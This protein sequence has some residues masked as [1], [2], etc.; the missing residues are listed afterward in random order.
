LFVGTLE[1]RK[2]LP[3][4]LEAIG[5]L[6]DRGWEGELVLVGGRGMDETKI[7]E[8]VERRRIGRRVLKLG[9]V[10]PKHLPTIYR[11]A[12]ALVNPSL[13]EGFGL[14]PLEAMACEVPV[15]VSDIPAHHEVTGEAA[16]Y[17]EPSSPNSI[18]DGIEQVWSNE[19]VRQSLVEM[20]LRRAKRFT[21][22]ETARK[23]LALYHRL[24]ESA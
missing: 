18:A 15:V 16:R 6:V 20:G 11:R 22:D 3:T 17:V 19:T 24:S 2:N 5:L 1:P 21:W 12:R 13:W 7:D 8:I 10:P 9:Y 14:P 23:T 4:L